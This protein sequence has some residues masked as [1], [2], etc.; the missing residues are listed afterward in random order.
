MIMLICI[1][2]SIYKDDDNDEY[3]QVKSMLMSLSTH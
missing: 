3:H 1:K 2:I